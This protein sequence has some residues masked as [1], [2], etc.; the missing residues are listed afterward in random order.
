MQRE[1]RLFEIEKRRF[2]R[3]GKNKERLKE[4]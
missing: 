1:R 2:Q 3:N 4:K